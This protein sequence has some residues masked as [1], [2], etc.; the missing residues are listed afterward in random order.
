MSNRLARYALLVSGALLPIASAQAADLATKITDAVVYASAA[1]VTRQGQFQAVA[2]ANRA[3]LG[4]LPAWVDVDSVRARIEGGNGARVLAVRSRVTSDDAYTEDELRK[5]EGAVDAARDAVEMTKAETTA[6][7]ADL[8]HLNKLMPWQLQKLPR[9]AAERP[10]SAAELKDIN[11]YLAIAKLENVKKSYDLKKQLR[12]QEETLKR[13]EEELKKLADH[14]KKST[15]EIT[16]DVSAGQAGPVTVAVS[17]L[18]S[19]ASWYPEHTIVAPGT[20][21]AVAMRSQGVVQQAT[22]EDWENVAVRLSAMHPFAGETTP[23]LGAWQVE[24]VVPCQ[25]P[26]AC[27]LRTEGGYSVR[28]AT[29][30]QTWQS[31]MPRDDDQKEALQRVQ[32]NRGRAAAVLRETQLRGATVEIP[33]STRISVK[34]DGEPVVAPVGE[35]NLQIERRFRAVPAVSPNVFEVGRLRNTTALPLLPGP[36]NLLS[37]TQLAGQR[38]MGFADLQERFDIEL[39]SAATVSAQRRLD[40]ANCSIGKLGTRTRLTAAYRIRLANTS[41]A[42]DAKVE[43]LDQL[44]VASGKGVQ[45]ELLSIEPRAEIAPNGV[46]EWELVIPAGQTKEVSFSFQ[47]EY[48]TDQPPALARA[49]ANRIE[50]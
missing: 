35:E 8:E 1:R 45:V 6:L 4:G 5:A 39:G 25:A 33:V 41:K 11:D 12:E 49:I 40:L 27:G 21:G 23:Q 43:L 48:P 34:G 10:V 31:S 46:A 2:G 13:A 37:G 24:P 26:D 28:L 38:R 44:P 50:D 22:G 30:D 19:G 14:P 29:L 36:V 9:E 32:A 47:I 16:V 3:T 20:G 42:A 7:Q 17:Y 18:I 15:T